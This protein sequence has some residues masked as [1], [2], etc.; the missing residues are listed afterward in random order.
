MSRSGR[1]F[2]FRDNIYNF[3]FN[4]WLHV[5]LTNNFLFSGNE[6]YYVNPPWLNQNVGASLLPD[7]G[8]R[9]PC[10]NCA[11][12]FRRQGTLTR[13]LTYE[14]GQPPRFQCPYCR[15]KSKFSWNLSHHIRRK[16]KSKA[17]GAKNIQ[18]Q[19]FKNYSH[20]ITLVA[21]LNT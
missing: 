12:M 3:F 21:S 13:H 18:E 8:L 15:H 9:F 11:R 19:W 14:C 4:I 7:P 1:F 6:C 16:H 2:L 10:T 5:S 17:V 20:E